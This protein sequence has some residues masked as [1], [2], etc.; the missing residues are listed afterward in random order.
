MTVTK[1]SQLAHL[2][3]CDLLHT[4][5]ANAK[6]WVIHLIKHTLNFTDSISPQ[7]PI[8][9]SITLKIYFRINWL[10]RKKKNIAQFH[11][12]QHSLRLEVKAFVVAALQAKLRKSLL[13]LC[14]WMVRK[15]TSKRRKDVSFIIILA[16]LKII[17]MPIRTLLSAHFYSEH[18]YQWVLGC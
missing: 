8:F 10:R 3:L 9:V 1:M 6:Y 7:M 15:A 2:Q 18:G 5:N 17:M 14:E 16:A 11:S 12:T 4:R 13:T